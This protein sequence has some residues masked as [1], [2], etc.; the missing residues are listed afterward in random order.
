MDTLNRVV[1]AQTLYK[2]SLL[3][4]RHTPKCLDFFLMSLIARPFIWSQ[5]IYIW[6]RKEDP[7]SPQK[8]VF[9]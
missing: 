3:N 4:A 1:F 8:L 6:Y 9:S 5:Q 7:E 2:I